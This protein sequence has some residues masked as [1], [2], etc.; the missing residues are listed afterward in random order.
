MVRAL[1]AEDVPDVALRVGI[2]Q[3]H[4]PARARE[5]RRHMHRRRRL[6][7]AAFHVDDGKLSHEA[8]CRSQAP[9]VIWEK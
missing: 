6:A 9:G 4:P 3:Q 2:N 1:D 5:P 8:Y 7:D